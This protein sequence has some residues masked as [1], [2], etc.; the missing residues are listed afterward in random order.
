VSTPLRRRDALR[1]W[2]L[3]F[4]PNTTPIA[5]VTLVILVFF[6]ASASVLG[7]E[8][9]LRA[10][11]PR[12]AAATTDPAPASRPAADPFALPP[13]R[14]DV[15]LRVGADGATVCDGLGLSGAPLDEGLSRLDLLASQVD[16]AR[17][18]LLVIPAP[19]VP[20]A[21]IVRLLDAGARLGFS[22]AGLADP[23]S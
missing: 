19:D 23:S 2:E 8:W 17:A 14:F 6:M 22:A 7:P 15:A 9:F 3:H 13:A 10:Q 12:P 4:G 21:D 18:V 20:Y 1:Q 16:P 5:D 11:L